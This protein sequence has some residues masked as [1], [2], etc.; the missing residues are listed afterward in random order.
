[1]PRSDGLSE[2]SVSPKRELVAP[3]VRDNLSN[4]GRQ[5]GIS[6]GIERL[7]QFRRHMARDDALFQIS[8][9]TRHREKIVQVQLVA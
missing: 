1:M 4:S 7:N 6:Y 8:R 5:A 9:E 2:S 3:F